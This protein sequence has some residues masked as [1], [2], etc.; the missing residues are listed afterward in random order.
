[1]KHKHGPAFVDGVPM[2]DKTIKEMCKQVGKF[3]IHLVSFATS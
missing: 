3:Q 1:M 2:L